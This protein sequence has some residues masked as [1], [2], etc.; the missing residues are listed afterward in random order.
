[1]MIDGVKMDQLEA[2]MENGSQNLIKY[3]PAT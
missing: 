3:F 2:N 1:M